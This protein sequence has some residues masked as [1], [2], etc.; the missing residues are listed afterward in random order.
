MWCLVP[1]KVKS[2]QPVRSWLERLLVE[3]EQLF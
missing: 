3:I 2:L 1:N